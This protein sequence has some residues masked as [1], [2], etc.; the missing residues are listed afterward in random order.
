M[1]TATADQQ[2]SSTRLV[3]H[4]AEEAGLFSVPGTVQ[5]ILSMLMDALCFDNYTAQRKLVLTLASLR[6][7]FVAEAAV[8]GRIRQVEILT[9]DVTTVAGNPDIPPRAT[10]SYPTGLATVGCALISH[11]LRVLF[12]CLTSC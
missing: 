9:S 7:I 10:F 4:S 5:I 8:E 12:L 1:W 3:W 11:V 6:T 2:C